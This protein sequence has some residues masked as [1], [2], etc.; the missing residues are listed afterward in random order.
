MKKFYV[1]QRL[2]LLRTLQALKLAEL[3]EIIQMCK[4]NLS[5][6]DNKFD[7]IERCESMIELAT[8]EIDSRKAA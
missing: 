6:S 7:F 4:A 2:T 3:K 8:A 5:D 1:I